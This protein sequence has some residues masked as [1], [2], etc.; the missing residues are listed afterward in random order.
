MTGSATFTLTPRSRP[1]VLRNVMAASDGWRVRLE[2]PRRTV[3]QNA[4]MW[5]ML[6]RISSAVNWHGEWLSADDWKDLFTAALRRHQRC[7]PGLDGGIVFFG[8]RTSEMTTAEMSDLMS[9]IEAFA[10]ER[11]I[12]A[13]E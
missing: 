10:A 2:P 8:L 11:G 12:E 13:G 3:P 7:A 9:L 4:R 5:A 6:A 1:Y